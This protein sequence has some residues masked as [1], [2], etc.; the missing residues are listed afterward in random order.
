MERIGRARLPRLIIIIVIAAF[1][2]FAAAEELRIGVISDKPYNI[3]EYYNP[4]A[5]YAAGRLKDETITGG[6]VVVTRTVPDML[7]KIKNREVDVVFETAFATI[8]MKEKAGM[9]PRLLVWKKGVREYRSVFFV[10]K[11]STIKTLKD[12][13]GK[14]IVFEHPDS[15]SAYLLPK[16]ELRRVGFTVL[17]GEQEARNGVVAYLFAKE[18][19]NQAFRV[20]QK[21]ADAGAFST[22]DWEDIPLKMRGELRIIHETKPVIRYIASFHPLLPS[23]LQNALVD[24]M[25]V[26][27]KD[28]EGAKALE[29]A[30][31]ITKIERLT[32]EDLKSLEYVKGIM[33]FI[34][35]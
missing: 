1:P 10:R 33:K 31:R 24:I 22:N 16:A 7:Q 27:D 6:K 20:L 19:V 32:G 8:D 26:M 17:P 23:K 34:G 29:K 9:I 35:E 13:N 15:T 18:D 21:K 4:L 5:Q 3:I 28:G 2:A 25:T 30:Q 12:L 11:E 14:T